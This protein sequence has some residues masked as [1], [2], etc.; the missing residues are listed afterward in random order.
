[1]KRVLSMLLAVCLCCG[2]LAG[3]GGKEKILTE[4]FDST[5]NQNVTISTCNFEVPKSWEKGDR[6]TGEIL[7]YYPEEGLLMVGYSEMD[8]SIL[9]KQAREEFIASFGEEFDGF[10]LK[11]EI[12][13]EVDGF[14]AYRHDVSIKMADDNYDTSMVTMDCGKGVVSFMMAVLET[15]DKDYSQDFSDIVSSIKRMLPF[16][17]TISEANS[18]F[19]ALEYGG[20]CNFTSSGIETLGDGTTMESLIDI[21]KG[22]MITVLGDS[23]EKITVMHM[24]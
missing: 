12:E 18:M 3:C 13:C 7:Y 16:E 14:K 9:D 8:Q 19:A 2:L 10:E 20:E 22:I 23:D 5:T 6:S 15:S 21:N 11:K 24:G 17:R 4:D 1:M